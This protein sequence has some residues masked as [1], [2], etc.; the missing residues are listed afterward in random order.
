M[1]GDR[2][3][4]GVPDE[5]S[6]DLLLDDEGYDTQEATLHRS[7]RLKITTTRERQKEALEKYG[8]VLDPANEMRARLNL[9]TD[10][11]IGTLSVE[12]LHFELN[13]QKMIAESIEEG[14]AQASEQRRQEKKSKSLHLPNGRTHK[15]MPEP[16]DANEE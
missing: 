5:L 3:S 9:L 12:R 1:L 13:W 4:S 14:I 11:F 6:E 10:M 2:W 15:V 7:L 8:V 16:E